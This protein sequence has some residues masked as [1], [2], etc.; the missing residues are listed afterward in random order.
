MAYRILVVLLATKIS[1]NITETK[2]TVKQIYFL[3][4]PIAT[5]SGR[6]NKLSFI[7]A[8]QKSKNR[9]EQRSILWAKVGLMFCPQILLLLAID[10]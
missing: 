5:R 7:T 4:D 6:P 10:L 3:T 9:Q 2:M 1:C 8:I